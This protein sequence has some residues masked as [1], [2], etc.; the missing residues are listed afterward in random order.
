MDSKNSRIIDNIFSVMDAMLF[1]EKRLSLTFQGV[2]LYPKEVHMLLYINSNSA[3]NA[4]MIAEAFSIT[5]GAVSQT[6]SRLVDKDMIIKERNPASPKEL[7]LTLST[8]GKEA[9]E[10]F[11]EFKKSISEK[12]ESYLSELS[13]GDKAVISEFLMKMEKVLKEV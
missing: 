11:I 5:K 1:I 12:Y 13:D 7:M 9:A 8:R 10:H 2:T 6:I 3:V 4:K